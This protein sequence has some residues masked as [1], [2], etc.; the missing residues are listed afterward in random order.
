MC[1]N[2]D[3]ILGSMPLQDIGNFFV[4]FTLSQESKFSGQRLSHSV[5]ATMMLLATVCLRIP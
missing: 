1:P 4:R 2:A 5:V 3:A